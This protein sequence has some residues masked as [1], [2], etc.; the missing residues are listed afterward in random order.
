MPLEDLPEDALPPTL[1]HVPMTRYDAI[2]I[3]LLDLPDTPVEGR[4]IARARHIPIEALL[5]DGGPLGAHQ[6]HKQPRQQARGGGLAAGA[7]ILLVGGQV[8]EQVGLDEGAVGPVVE[9]ELL[10]GV[11]VH[12]LVVEVGVEVGVDAEVVLVPGREDVLEA[13][14][15]RF[16]APRAF[17]AQPFGPEQPGGGEGRR[18]LRDED[19][20]FGVRR[21][22]VFDRPAEAG[23][24]LVH[25]GRQGD[26]GED[27]EGAGPESD[28]M[29]GWL[30]SVWLDRRRVRTGSTNCSSSSDFE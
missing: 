6:A 29:V 1:N 16:L 3:E 22:E 15:G 2:E 13:G 21:D 19:V 27:G 20:V 9:D 23:E 26:G 24:R 4:P 11:A 17:L 10:V 30:W 5:P 18:P 12:V 7:R 8:K 28:W 14:A 25:F